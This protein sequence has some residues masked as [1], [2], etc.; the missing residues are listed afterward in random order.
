MYIT[1]YRLEKDNKGPFWWIHYSSNKTPTQ[2]RISSNLYAI[3]HSYLE[4][5]WLAIINLEDKSAEIWN[6]LIPENDKFRSGITA[7]FTVDDLKAYFGSSFFKMLCLVGF[8]ITEVKCLR[9]ECIPAI[10]GHQVWCSSEAY[11]RV[12]SYEFEES[13]EE[14]LRTA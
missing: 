3:L 7:C 8:T 6:E 1:L 12:R 9:D 14:A 4:S 10:D 5:R 2:S 13:F 11:E